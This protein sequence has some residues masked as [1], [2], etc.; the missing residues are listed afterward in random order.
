MHNHSLYF[1]YHLVCQTDFPQRSKEAK[2]EGSRQKNQMRREVLNLCLKFMFVFTEVTYVDEADV[3]FFG[4]VASLQVAS[5]VHVIVPN[6]AG[7]DVRGGDAFCPLGGS[8]HSFQRH[9][10]EIRISH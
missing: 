7:D 10:F 6:D 2:K 1:Y 4:R 5:H 3:E 9:N 8:E